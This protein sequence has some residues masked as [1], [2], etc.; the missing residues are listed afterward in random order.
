MGEAR[1]PEPDALMFISPDAGGR[2]QI[3]PG[4]YLEGAP[5]LVAEISAS[6]IAKDLGRKLQIYE[7]YG[8]EE[9]IVC[10]TETDEIR[11]FRL[12]NGKYQRLVADAQGI[13]RSEVFPGLWLDVPAIIGG[14]MRRALEVLAHGL[15]TAEHEAFSQRLDR[16]RANRKELE[17]GQS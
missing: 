1:D 13:L 9:Y 4:D 5:E 12:R 2:C 3:V 17:G 10:L 8:A 6:T 15:A 11:W 14:D 16:E 7:E